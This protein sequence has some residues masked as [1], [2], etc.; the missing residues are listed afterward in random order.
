MPNNPNPMHTGIAINIAT[1]AK[2]ITRKKP[3]K[4]LV[5]FDVSSAIII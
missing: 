3:F 2:I 1:K 4:K 5:P